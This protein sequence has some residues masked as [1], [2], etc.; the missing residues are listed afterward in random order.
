MSNQAV[1]VYAE[2]LKRQKQETEQSNAD[3]VTSKSTRK[4]T[5]TTTSPRGVS[6]D[7]S[8]TLPRDSSRELPRSEMGA[9]PRADAR[10]DSRALPTRDEIQEFWAKV[11]NQQLYPY[12][13]VPEYNEM[14]NLG[15]PIPLAAPLDLQ[16]YLPLISRQ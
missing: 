7:T 3:K 4:L 2:A 16:V 9:P 6:R 13:L 1:A 15:P 8:R 14:N 11:D 5:R 12:G 10:E